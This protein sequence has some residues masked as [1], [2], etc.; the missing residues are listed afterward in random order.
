MKALEKALKRVG[1][2][3]EMAKNMFDYEK[4]VFIKDGK[5]L[6]CGH[7]DSM[8]CKCYGKEHEGETAV[9]TDHCH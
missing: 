5:Y 4:Q 7:P 3:L 6:R 1:Y 9:I 8:D 2:N